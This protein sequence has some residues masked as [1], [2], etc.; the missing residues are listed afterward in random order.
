MLVSLEELG[1][2]ANEQD[3]VDGRLVYFFLVRIDIK[4]N[5]SF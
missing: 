2:L 4:V 3:A 5:V 1:L